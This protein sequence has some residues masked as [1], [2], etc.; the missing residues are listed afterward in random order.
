MEVEIKGTKARELQFV[1]K[2]RAGTK[3]AEVGLEKRG[4]NGERFRK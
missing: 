1:K 4:K 2:T 3:A